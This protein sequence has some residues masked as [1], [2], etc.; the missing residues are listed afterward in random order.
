MSHSNK[1]SWMEEEENRAEELTETGQ[2]SNADA[3]Q[4]VRVV[5]EP[6]RKQKAFYIQEKHS[7]MFETLVFDQ[8]RG[9]G[10][11]AP[12]LAEEALELLFAKYGENYKI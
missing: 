3:P 5:R 9:K 8:K 7:H 4:L 10:K 2:T 6:K 11:K 12:Q 1:P